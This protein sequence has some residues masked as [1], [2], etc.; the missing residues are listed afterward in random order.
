MGPG[1]TIRDSG[2][3]KPCDSSADLRVFIDGTFI[4]AFID[5]RSCDY[6]AASIFIFTGNDGRERG[7]KRKGTEFSMPSSH[8]PENWKWLINPPIV[9][10]LTFTVRD[11]RNSFFILWRNHPAIMPLCNAEFFDIQFFRSNR[12]IKILRS[13]ISYD[14]RIRSQP[15]P[16]YR[17][18]FNTSL[19]IQRD[20]FNG[21]V[22]SC[23]RQG[24]TIVEQNP[25]LP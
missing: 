5:G 25:D 19:H 24:S 3:T 17:G 2:I 16:G 22:F 6:R 10:A 15:L 18:F 20:K 21:Y 23:A 4:R 11:S 8:Q 7:S 13:F 12:Q 14:V 9:I 1:K